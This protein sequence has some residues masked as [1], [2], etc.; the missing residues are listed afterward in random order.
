MIDIKKIPKKIKTKSNISS[1]YSTIL[2][3]IAIIISIGTLGYQIISNINQNEK[4]DF[5]IWVENKPLLDADSITFFDEEAFEIGKLKAFSTTCQIH[6]SNNSENNVNIRYFANL[7]GFDTINLREQ[8]LSEKKFIVLTTLN[9]QFNTEIKANTSRV[10]E[11]PILITSFSDTTYMQFILVCENEYG[12]VYDVYKRFKINCSS[13][14]DSNTNSFIN[15]KRL[16][17][18]DLIIY[19]SLKKTFSLEEKNS[20]YE[21]LAYIE[22]SRKEKEE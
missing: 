11:F 16:K 14:I 12:G 19:P 17:Q 9:E 7:K 20:F 6:V 15:S 13:F 3:T 8:I 2:S 1:K 21:Y 18:P 4:E 22:D 5:R 10:F